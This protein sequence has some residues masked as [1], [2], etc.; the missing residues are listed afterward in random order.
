MVVILSWLVIL[1]VCGQRKPV[2]WTY[3]LIVRGWLIAV[4][5]AFTNVIFPHY[6]VFYEMW[7]ARMKEKV[8]TSTHQKSIP[9]RLRKRILWS[10]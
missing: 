5:F 4:H 3:N 10:L 2:K 7:Y 8:T 1:Y 6:F 9:V